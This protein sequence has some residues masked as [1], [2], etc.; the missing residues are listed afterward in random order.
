MRTI[1]L[2]LNRTEQNIT[3]KNQKNNQTTDNCKNKILLFF[4]CLFFSS[5]PCIH[6]NSFNYIT[7][8]YTTIHYIYMTPIRSFLHIDSLFFF[9]NISC[10]WSLDE[11]VNVASAYASGTIDFF[12][13]SYDRQS[14]HTVVQQ[15]AVK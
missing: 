5:G 13:T 1:E 14:I 9:N 4:L 3:E 6:S 10:W 8:I 11:T 15:P 12:I 7:F 2:N